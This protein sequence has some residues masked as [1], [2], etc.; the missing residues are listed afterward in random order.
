MPVIPNGVGEITADWLSG[1]FREE[2][3]LIGGQIKSASVE[4]LDPTKAIFGTLLRLHLE[5]TSDSQGL[6]STMIAK[7]PS[8]NQDSMEWLR[9]SGGDRTEVSFYREI[10]KSVGLRV[11]ECYLSARDEETGRFVILLEDLSIHRSPSTEEG[12]SINEIESVVRS[13]A[14]SHAVWWEDP[15]LNYLDWLRPFDA[16]GLS[17]GFLVGWKI[18]V[19]YLGGDSKLEATGEQ[20]MLT[21][22]ESEKKLASPPTTLLHMD[23]RLEN[24]FFAGSAE[25]PEAIFIDWQN[26]RRGR[27]ATSLGTFLAFLPQRDEI[28]D[29]ITSLYHSELVRAGVLDYPLEDLREDYRI[30]ILRRLFT[31]TSVLGSVGAENSQGIALLDLLSRFEMAKLEKYL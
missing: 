9:R 1:V 3:N 13:L 24:L 5:Y 21:V 28:E 16:T 22:G 19:D 18:L 23:I 11:P 17:T 25:N 29:S 6:P 26:V 2:G 8:S 12:L 14:A 4:V 31:P 27:G 30:A 15:R 7:L 10:S 20:I